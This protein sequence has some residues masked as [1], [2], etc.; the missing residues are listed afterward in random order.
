MTNTLKAKRAEVTVTGSLIRTEVKVFI[1][2]TFISFLISI[3]Q[4]NILTETSHARLCKV[5]REE[6]TV[7]VK[8]ARKEEETKVTKSAREAY[9]Y[10]FN[11]FFSDFFSKFFFF[12]WILLHI[13]SLREETSKVKNYLYNSSSSASKS[14]H[15]SNQN[16]TYQYSITAV[17]VV[18]Q[19]GPKS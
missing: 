14:P 19:E 17:V 11:F 6:T 5:S 8:S 15:H 9:A 16:P 4:I 10:I 3:T 18:Q 7:T 2:F 1:S 12:S 13:L